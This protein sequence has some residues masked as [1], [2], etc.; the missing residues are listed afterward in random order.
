MW[1]QISTISKPF[2]NR[3]I[4]FSTEFRNGGKVCLE[5]S[6]FQKL[7]NFLKKEL[8]R[9]RH[10]TS[11]PTGKILNTMLL[12]RRRTNSDFWQKR[13]WTLWI[14]RNSRQLQTKPVTNLVYQRWLQNHFA[15]NPKHF[16]RKLGEWKKTKLK[17]YKLLRAHK[18]WGTQYQCSRNFFIWI[19]QKNDWHNISERRVT[20][21]NPNEILECR[22]Q[23][24]W[25]TIC[26]M[27]PSWV[28]FGFW[29]AEESDK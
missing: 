9:K 22:Y 23:G 28:P 16:T 17:P 10:A 14:V 20:V 19:S 29:M 15:A 27:V 11:L 6:L 5:K 3:R 12:K 8:Q 7:E 21:I 2:R 13:K 26:R 18:I 24:M 1:K 25:K 4:N